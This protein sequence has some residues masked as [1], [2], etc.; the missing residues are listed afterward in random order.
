[1]QTLKVEAAQGRATIKLGTAPLIAI[2][3]VVA[4]LYR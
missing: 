4:S 2:T 3:L 1:M